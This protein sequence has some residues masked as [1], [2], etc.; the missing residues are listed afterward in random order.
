MPS[1]LDFNSDGVLPPGDYALTLDELETSLLV[2]GPSD[3][4]RCKSWNEPWRLQL[5][6]NLGILVN[7]LWRVGITEVF[8]D[9][10]FVEDKDRPNDIDG[11]FVC[12]LERLAS[13]E[14]ERAL[15]EL[16][17]KKVWTWDW[18]RRVPFHGYPKPQLP[19]WHE[20]RVELYPHYGQKSGIRDEY[21]NE[22]LF[23]AAFRRT[24]RNGKPRGIVK[25]VRS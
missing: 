4:E 17:P 7:Q 24:R 13:G 3:R 14:L 25:V 11:Y 8:I 21:G 23:P 1:L 10:S 15:N 9:G 19:M 5:V 12:E 6:R 18:D 20:Y 22:L 2:V 16:D